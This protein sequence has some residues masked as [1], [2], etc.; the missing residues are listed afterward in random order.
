MCYSIHF[1]LISREKPGPFYSFPTY[2]H[3]LIRDVSDGGV[4]LYLGYK[5]IPV[6]F[7]LVSPC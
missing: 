7:V 6:H 4:E 5:W 2:P 1:K 3:W